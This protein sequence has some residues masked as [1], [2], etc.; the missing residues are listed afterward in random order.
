VRLYLVRFGKYWNDNNRTI[1]IATM[2]NKAQTDW[3]R[4]AITL[5]QNILTNTYEVQMIIQG[6][7]GVNSKGLIA[8]DDIMLADGRCQQSQLICEDGTEIRRDQICNFVND[9]PSGMDELN[10]GT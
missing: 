8:I 7:I 5:D 4:V 2:A 1:T 6:Q 10:C 9:C 3:T